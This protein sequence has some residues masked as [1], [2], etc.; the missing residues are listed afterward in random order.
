MPNTENVFYKQEPYKIGHINLWFVL[1]LTGFAS[2]YRTEDALENNTSNITS[3]PRET[4]QGDLQT[5]T[6]TRN[7]YS[8]AFW[9]QMELTDFLKW[10]V[11]TV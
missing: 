11:F 9:S 3:G 4:V 7:K 2:H 8:P 6:N 1:V 5:V 10:Q